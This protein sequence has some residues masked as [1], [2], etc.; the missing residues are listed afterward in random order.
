MVQAAR[1]PSGV[2]EDIQL[3]IRQFPVEP[4]VGLDELLGVGGTGKRDTRGLA[5][6]AVYTVGADEPAR[7]QALLATVAVAQL[8]LNRVLPLHEPL[9]AHATLDHHAQPGQV[10]GEDLFGLVLRQHQQPGVGG[11]QLGHTDQLCAEVKL[12]QWAAS[13]HLGEP[14]DRPPGRQRRIDHAH[15]LE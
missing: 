15:V 10:I 7:C 9:E 6:A 3:A 5:H 2:G 4:G 8:S 14:L 12:N 13:Q 1:T 11:V